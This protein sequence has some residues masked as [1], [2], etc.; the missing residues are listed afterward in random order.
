MLHKVDAEA[1]VILFIIYSISIFCYSKFHDFFINFCIFLLHLVRW[2]MCPSCRPV[3]RP[4]ERIHI[5]DPAINIRNVAQ[6]DYEPMCPICQNTNNLDK[7]DKDF[8]N[9]ECAHTFHRK[10]LLQWI[11]M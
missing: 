6:P 9:T 11:K 3:I 10:C 1:I 8:I 7:V 4:G 5:R 2:S